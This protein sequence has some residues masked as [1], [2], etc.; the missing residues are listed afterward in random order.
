MKSAILRG[1]GALDTEKGICGIISTP[2]PSLPHTSPRPSPEPHVKLDYLSH[3]HILHL[4]DRCRYKLSTVNVT[5][6]VGE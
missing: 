4:L 5:E 3:F 2:S 1:I 6:V